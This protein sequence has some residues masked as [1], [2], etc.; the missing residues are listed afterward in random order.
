MEE[1]EDLFIEGCQRPEPDGYGLT[2][3]QAQ[4]LWEQVVAFSGFGFNQGH[5]T[6]YAAVSYRSAY[7]KT[8]WPAAFLCARLAD[9]GGYHHPAIYM[10]EARRLGI[11]L[12]PPHVNRSNAKFTLTWEIGVDEQAPRLWM[13]LDAVRDLRQRT[14][15]EI[16]KARENAPFINVRD[17]VLRVD[18]QTKELIHLIQ[19]GGL[20][21]LGQNRVAMIAE[22]ETIKRG[23]T[24][25]QMAFSFTESPIAAESPQQAIAWEMQ[26]LGYPMSVHPLDLHPE[27]PDHIPLKEL[28]RFERQRVSIVGVRLPGWTG[29]RGFFFGDKEAYII[30]RQERGRAQP[31]PWKPQLL[32]GQWQNDGMGTSWF[33][34]ESVT[35][36]R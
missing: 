28:D 16:I 35:P 3:E 17:L 20:D 2:K 34:A 4:K 24:E 11:S 32:H 15:H 18:F 26:V 23:G 13:G 33:Q 7:V 6:A 29:G 19:C 5:A 8:H 10:A 30:V 25:K 31:S 1:V 14:I 12:E 27:L 36:L 21:G 9:R 22:A